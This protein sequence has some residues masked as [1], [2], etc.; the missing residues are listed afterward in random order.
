MTEGTV[1]KPR[2]NPRRIIERP[3]LTRLLDESPARIKML[4]AP[5]GY[6]K[7]TLARQWL[8]SRSLSSRWIACTPAHSDVA[9]LLTSIATACSKTVDRPSPLTIE[10][11]QS[12]AEPTRERGLLLDLL[13]DDLQDWP[14]S[15]W[16][17]LDDYHDLMTSPHAEEIV[18][19]ILARTRVPILITS[20]RRPTW[21]T[22]RSLFYGEL[23]EITRSQLAMTG[24]EV[25]EALGDTRQ[26]AVGDLVRT[27]KGWPAF[28]ALA[29]GTDDAHVREAVTRATM[30]DYLATE[31]YLAADEHVQKALRDLSLSPREHGWLLRQLHAPKEAMRIEREALRLGM[32]TEGADGLLELHPLLQDILKRQFTD[33]DPDV[34]EAAFMKL[35]NV[36]VKHQRWDEAFALLVRADRPG[37]LP[38]LLTVALDKLLLAGRSASL[39]TG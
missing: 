10:R 23:I 22:A 3:R 25:N 16:L 12:A 27:A 26:D 5:A 32:L 24:N 21:A 28:V 34:L 13:V 38:D 15:T 30:Y 17:I 7:T 9:V 31:I 33:A 35:W 2:I 29:A 36:L 6:G 19:S 37:Y 8:A 39:R 4:V 11:L 18:Q 1:D 14:S 20:R